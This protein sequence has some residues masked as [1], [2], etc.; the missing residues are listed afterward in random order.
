MHINGNGNVG[1]GIINPLAKFEL[2]GE[3]LLVRNIANTDG[4]SSIMVAHSVNISNFDST[5]TSIR[6]ITQNARDNNYALQF[7]TEDSFIV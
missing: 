5:G 4:V 2:N 7:F 1:I 6:S 3:N